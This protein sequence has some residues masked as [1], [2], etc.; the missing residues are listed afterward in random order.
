MTYTPSNGFPARSSRVSNTTLLLQNLFNYTRYS[1]LVCAFTIGGCGPNTSINATTFHGNLQ[2]YFNNVLTLEIF[3]TAP[4]SVPSIVY[5]R[6]STLT[7]ID[8]H[9]ND[10][11]LSKFQDEVMSF[12]KRIVI[13]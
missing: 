8:H 2:T 4:T 1:I 9:Q 6:I 7:N 12:L 11:A 3:N 10:A 5:F 13:H